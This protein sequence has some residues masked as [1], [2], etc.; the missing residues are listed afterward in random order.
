MKVSVVIPA[1]NE[2]DAII[3]VLREIPR[4]AVSETIVVD[5]GSRDRTALV[6]KGLGA[7]VVREDRRGY[8]WACL[9]GLRALDSTAEVVVFLDGDHSDYPDELG[10][11][12]EPIETGGADLV[13]GSRVLGKA[14]RGSLTPQQRFGNKLACFLI[15]RVWG[16]RFTDL[17]PFRAI[18]R[19]ALDQLKLCDKTFGWNVEMQIKAIRKGLRISEVPVD[20]RRRIGKSKISGTFSGTIR[21]GWK[22]LAGILQY[23]RVSF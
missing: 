22:I 1:L 4:D 14:E 20:Y 6:A 23:S 13:I 12:L 3:H 11:L 19:S 5:N 17:G 18:R 21:A 9:A 15:Y 7:K 16:K 2:E 8:G 10:R